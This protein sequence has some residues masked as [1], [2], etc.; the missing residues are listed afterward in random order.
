MC[1]PGELSPTERP[2]AS[3][4]WPLVL[5]LAD[6]AV[7]VDRERRSQG[8]RDGTTRSDP[9][10]NAPVQRRASDLTFE[11]DLSDG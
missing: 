8:S 7:R 9:D 4:L 10:S 6:I 5:V 2:Q 3:P 11:E 1:S